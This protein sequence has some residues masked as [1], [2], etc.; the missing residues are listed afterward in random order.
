[1]G[2]RKVL[3][4]QSPSA[5]G[6]PPFSQGGHEFPGHFADSFRISKL[7]LLRGSLERDRDWGI[8]RE[9]GHCVPSFAKGLGAPNFRGWLSTAGTKPTGLQDCP[10][11][12]PLL[13][14]SP[15]SSQPP[16]VTKGWGFAWEHE[17][18]GARAQ[19]RTQAFLSLGSGGK[20][21]KGS[22]P[23]Q[24]GRLHVG[25][26]NC[27]IWLLLVAGNVPTWGHPIS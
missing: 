13:S 12:L 5:K 3:P 21:P 25:C 19:K 7:E 6:A 9:R 15:P 27:L 20:G 23:V 22:F 10:G 2:D 26:F 11:E 8:K 4:Y 1:M 17:E 18:A 14:F 24:M 16:E